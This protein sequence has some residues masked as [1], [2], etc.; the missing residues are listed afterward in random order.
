MKGLKQRKDAK[1]KSVKLTKETFQRVATAR[2]TNADW[3]IAFVLLQ[4]G[5]VIQNIVL[6]LIVWMA[7]ASFMHS[8]LLSRFDAAH[9]YIKFQIMYLINQSYKATRL[10]T[11]SPKLSSKS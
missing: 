11:V 3:T 6:V 4:V 9:S 5:D 8:N 2:K 7:N 1:N 10:L